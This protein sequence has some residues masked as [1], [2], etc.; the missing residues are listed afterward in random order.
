MKKFLSGVC[1][2]ALILSTLSG[3]S[4][5][6]KT[7]GNTNTDSKEKAVVTLIQNKVEIQEQLENAAKDF[8]KSQ[9]DVEV[10]ILGAAGDDLV[11]V[12]QTQ[13][14]SDPGKAP[15]IFTCGSGSEF[16]KFFNYMTTL[17]DTAASKKI[18]KGQKE[19][20][21]KDGKLYGLPV[22]IE[23]FGLV[24]NKTLFEK[25][26]VKAEDI[27]SMDDLIKACEKLEKV[28]GVSKAIAFGKETYFQFMH[29]FNWPFAVMDN[30]KE[31]INNVISGKTKLKDVPEVKQYVQ[32][33][34]KLKTHTN[35]AKDTYD[36]QVAGFAQGKYAMIHQG[37]WVQSLL[38]DYDVDFEYGMMP[39]PFNANDSLAVGNTNFFRVNKNATEAQQKGAKKFLDWLYTDKAG[40]T[41]VT[42][43]F[44]LIPAYEGFD[45]KDMDPLA[46]DVSKY[47]QE[48]K[49]VPW[50]FNLFPAGVDKDCSSAMEKYYAGKINT[51][52]LLDEINKVW[53]DAVSK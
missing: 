19:D 3:C 18:V 26:G 50:T 49:T 34:D 51:D 43:K 37:N 13:F 42:E 8:N 16:E 21:M 11:K 9:N 24:Y 31:V 10:Q 47:S 45:T 35:L 7:E 27:K 5:T 29:P 17:D 39:V 41:Y 48:G 20:A 14:A 44:K 52:Q 22:A 12:L 32:D 28:Q 2:A 33:L 46:A 25:A 40:Q 23:G 1:A 38:D 53:T 30:Y 36:E 6:T 15:T 4:S